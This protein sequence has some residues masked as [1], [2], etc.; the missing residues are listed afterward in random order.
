MQKTNEGI[1]VLFSYTY[2]PWWGYAL[3]VCI[4]CMVVSCILYNIH[5]Q[6]TLHKIIYYNIRVLLARMAYSSITY[7]LCMHSMMLLTT[8]YYVTVSTYSVHNLSRKFFVTCYVNKSQPACN[9]CTISSCGRTCSIF[10]MYCT[11]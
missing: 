2:H 8:K 5:Q 4:C 9:T 7:G 6:L 11:Q 3:T 10:I 1:S